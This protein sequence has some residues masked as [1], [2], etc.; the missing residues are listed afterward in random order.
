MTIE[1][2]DALLDWI[3]VYEKA[4]AEANEKLNR[5]R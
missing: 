1:Q 5:G 2:E 3:D 4:Q